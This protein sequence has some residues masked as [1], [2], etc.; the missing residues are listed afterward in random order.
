MQALAQYIARE[1]ADK[2]VPRGHLEPLVVEGQQELMEHRLGVWLSNT[3]SRRDKLT[4]DQRTA[5]AEL[6]MALPDRPPATGHSFLGGPLGQEGARALDRVG[7]H[8]PVGLHCHPGDSAKRAV[9]PRTQLRDLACCP[10][11]RWTPL[12]MTG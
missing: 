12:G 1:G 9:Q 11:A 5:L 6:G 4:H 10:T 3:K 7:G 8:S 2:P